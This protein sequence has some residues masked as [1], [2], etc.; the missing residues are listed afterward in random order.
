LHSNWCAY[1]VPD[2]TNNWINLSEDNY[3]EEFM[4]VC[5]KDVKNGKGKDTILN[6][7]SL[8]VATNRDEWVYV[9]NEKN[10]LNKVS[11]FANSYNQEILRWKSSK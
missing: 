6:S 4:P 10:L 2:K 7:F 8:G 5:S 1:Y 3:W 11:Y 9:F